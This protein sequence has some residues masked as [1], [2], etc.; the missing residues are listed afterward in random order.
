MKLLIVEDNEPLAANLAEIFELEGYS[1]TYAIDGRSGLDKA[2]LGF[3][4]ALVDVRLPDMT[5]TKLVPKLKNISPDAE[6]LIAT[7]NADVETAIEAVQAGAAAYLTKPVRAEELIVAVERAREKVELRR[8]ERVLQDA[9]EASERRLRGLIGSVQALIVTID[10]A[11]K[12]RYTNP[13]ATAILGY[14][15]SELTGLNLVDAIAAP[16]HRERCA[17][18]LRSENNEAME[19]D[20]TGKTTSSNQRNNFVFFI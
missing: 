16:H 17:E 15:P 18:A 7:A 19:A 1:A 11:G 8:R 9:L 4:V 3:D 12:I 13:A 20:F 6:V 10:S 14:K 2:K 5:G